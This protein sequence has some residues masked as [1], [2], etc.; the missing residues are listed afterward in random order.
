[1]YTVNFN[2]SIEPDKKC[3]LCCLTL[4]L[5]CLHWAQAFL[6]LP[7]LRLDFLELP[8]PSKPAFAS[9]SS[10]FAALFFLRLFL[11]VGVDVCSTSSLVV[12]GPDELP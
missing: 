11:F 4:T 7:P 8:A 10:P 9:S 5:R 1:M 6:D 2:K 3:V 12:T